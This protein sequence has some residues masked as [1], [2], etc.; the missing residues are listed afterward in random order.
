MGILESLVTGVGTAVAKG[1]LKRW[2]KD[3]P[4]IQ[5]ASGALIDILTKGVKDLIGRRRG[6]R[7]FEDIAEKVAQDI[8]DLLKFIGVDL[9]EAEKLEVVKAAGNLVGQCVD[10][11]AFGAS[12]LAKNSLQPGELCKWFREQDVSRSASST[13]HWSDRQELLYERVL[14][15]SSQYIIDLAGQLPGFTEKTLAEV[16]QRQDHITGK[17]DQILEEVRRIRARITQESTTEAAFEEK[18]R[19][20]VIR[21]LDE[22]QL[23]GVDLAQTSKR[24]QMSVAYVTL[25]VERQLQAQEREFDSRPEDLAGE[26]SAADLPEE[27]EELDDRETVPVD[28]ALASSERLFVR[29]PA[30]S[31]KTTLLQWIAV[32]T[33]SQLLEDELATWNERIPFFI[34]L[35]Q[36]AKKALPRPSEFPTL[37]DP[38][39]LETPPE[40][41]AARVLDSGRALVLI[42][43]LDEMPQ[44]N[45]EEVREWIDDLIGGFPRA[46]FVLTS[47]PYAAE[48]GWLTAEGFTDAELQDMSMKDVRTFVQHWHDAVSTSLQT[49]ED[50]ADLESLC[51]ALQ[52]TI[53]SNRSLQ[54]LATSPLLCAMLCA[55][56]RERVQNLPGD[57]I[58]LYR[59]CIEMF[60]RR[61]TERKIDLGDYPNVGNR[62]KITALGDLGLWLIRN[63][64]TMA[65]QQ[66][67]DTRLEQSLRAM[68][69]SVEGITGAH[70]RRLCVERSGILRQPEPDR[71]DFPH[72]TFQEYLAAQAALREGCAGELVTN[73]HRDQWREVLI[74]AA[75]LGNEAQAEQIVLGIIERGDNEKSIRAALYL[76]ATVCHETVVRFPEGSS[77]SATVKKKLQTIIPPKNITSARELAQAG[78]LVVPYL[79]YNERWRAASAAACVRTL[80]LVGGDAAY[81]AIAKYRGDSRAFIW[82]E[83]VYSWHQASDLESLKRAFAEAS[84]HPMGPKILHLPGRKVDDLSPIENLINLTDLN[85]YGTQVNDLTPVASL[86]NLSGLNLGNTLITDLCPLANLTNLRYLSLYQTQI[87][88]LSPLSNLHNLTVL[89]I[90]DTEVADLAPL[91]GLSALE[92]LYLRN[93]NVTD[94]GPLADLPNLRV[95]GPKAPYPRQGS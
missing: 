71:I 74:L 50:R 61:D 42:D 65:S 84:V 24:Y 40:G 28:L 16:L 20:A 36:F 80:A 17:A 19:R 51:Q 63:D 21:E 18:Y 56:H 90:D 31:G 43:G 73:A 68:G 39:T 1:T 6:A 92:R 83:I 55:L 4:E 8:Y 29:G 23:F 95:Y 49:P 2:L 93:T 26:E 44:E 57:R 45:R 69:S 14:F 30:G 15:E 46:T 82:Q 11:P 64:L 34:R 62:Q 66:Q 52:E 27:E 13:Q 25:L 94:R 10:S 78:D 85:L 79:G 47:R 38:V 41:W 89:D 22:L 12:L 60:F 7:Q 35:R 53:R 9:S 58:E 54:R 77:A 87:S 81:A 32:M 37:I 91:A 59:A 3:M 75:G 88:D 70:L 5:G 72:R 48:E 33:A 67:V 86:A 76:L